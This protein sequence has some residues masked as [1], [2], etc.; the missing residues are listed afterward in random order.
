MFPGNTTCGDIPG[1]LVD[2]NDEKMILM[3]KWRK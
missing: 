1:E 2:L 3:E